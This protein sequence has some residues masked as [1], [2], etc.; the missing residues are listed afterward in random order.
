MQSWTKWEITFQ[1]GNFSEVMQNF[2]VRKESLILIVPKIEKRN[3]L[4]IYI[5]MTKGPYLPVPYWEIINKVKTFIIWTLLLI[6][7]NI[8]N[9]WC[10][11]SFLDFALLRFMLCPGYHY[12]IIIGITCSIL[13]LKFL[14]SGKLS[15]SDPQLSH[16]ALNF[17]YL[18]RHISLSEQK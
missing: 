14:I 18:T 4:Y 6:C 8:L 2:N 9:L 5:N 13:Y 1:Q 16:I 11:L 17:V 7:I 15:A 12:L 10:V 3:K